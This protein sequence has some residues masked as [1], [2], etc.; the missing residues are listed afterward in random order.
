M[1]RQ[2]LIGSLVDVLSANLRRG[3]VDVAAFEVGK[4]YGRRGDQPNEWWRLGFVLAGSAEPAAY[5]R[6]PRAYDLDD[7]KG[8]VELIARR[9]GATAPGYEPA[10]EEAV[11]HPGRTARVAG[12]DIA[13]ILG[14]LHPELVERLELKAGAVI[15]GELSIA[16]LSGGQLSAIRS[17]P[18]ARYPAV[19]RDL[20]VVVRETVPAASVGEVIRGAAGPLLTG[21]VLFDIYRGVPLAADEKSLAHRLTFQS[22]DRT[23]TEP[24]IDQAVEAVTRALGEQLEGRLR[25]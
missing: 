17:T 19:E 15:A 4:G 23:L 6:R 3:I 20:A 11:F 8:L 13:G 25:T 16:G 7:A 12:A 24:E 10:A 18:P 22:A 21:V 2:G 9:L 14:Q 5:N 1:L